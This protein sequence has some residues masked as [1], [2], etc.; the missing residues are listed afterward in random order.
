MTAFPRLY[1]AIART[2]IDAFCVRNPLLKAA[3]HIAC[4]PFLVQLTRLALKMEKRIARDGDLKG[5]CQW[6]LSIGASSLRCQGADT[7]PRSGPLLFV[8]NH[9]G[10]GDAHALL[11][12]SPRRDTKLLARD[13]GILPGLAHFR[14][15]VIVVE[16][17]RPQAALRA[18]LRHLRAGG[19]LLLYPRG[20]IEPDPALYPAAAQASLARWSRSLTLFARHAPGLN[21]VPVAV[22]GLISRRALL[23]VIVR[24]YRDHDR[25]HFL[26]ATFQMLFPRYR[27]PAVRLHFGEALTGK[28]ATLP[29]AQAQMQTLLQR[30]SAELTQGVS[31]E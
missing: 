19:S 5:A 22:G 7:I 24:R 2:V 6:L 9:A 20:E 4:A 14:Q 21:I 12:A 30:L 15:H 26:A 31:A 18:G 28:R 17:E 11:S 1:R 10:L 25:R 13:F 3:L 16:P 27:D 8:G 23:N 29:Q